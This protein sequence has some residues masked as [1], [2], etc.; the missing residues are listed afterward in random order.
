MEGVLRIGDRPVIGRMTTADAEQ[1]TVLTTLGTT[2]VP[3]DEIVP[4][5][6][7]A[8]VAYLVQGPARGTAVR[9]IPA[10]Y[11]PYRTGAHRVS[12][13]MFAAAPLDWSAG[14]VASTPSPFSSSWGATPAAPTW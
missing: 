14:G 7:T 10:T 5:P 2:T 4:V 12:S 6:G 1:L 3:Q 8:M 13:A 11:A 9:P